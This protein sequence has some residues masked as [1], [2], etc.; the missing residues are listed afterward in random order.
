MPPLVI[1]DAEPVFHQD[2]VRSNDRDAPA[3]RLQQAGIATAVHYPIPVHRTAAYRADTELEHT[4]LAAA[5]VLSL[6]SSRPHRP[7]PRQD[8][9]RGEPMT[10]RAG[11]IGLGMM[12]RHHARVLRS[13]PGSRL[14]GLPTSPAICTK[15]PAAR[16]SSRPSNS[17]SIS[18]C[19]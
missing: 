10:L 16:P 12:G 17:C 3:S 5:Q 6:P 14:P 8:R 15:P 1:N 13:L 19:W 7:G 11:V 9:E 2:V 18:A 4:G